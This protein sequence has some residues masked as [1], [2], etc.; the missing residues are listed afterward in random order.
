M[1]TRWSGAGRFRGAVLGL[2]RRL[3]FLDLCLVMPN[4]APDRR[5]GHGM[6][7][8]D[9][10]HNAPDRGTFDAAVSTANDRKRGKR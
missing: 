7:T 1:S 3:P 2:R 8:R 4:D 6:M 9:V 10:T 5:A